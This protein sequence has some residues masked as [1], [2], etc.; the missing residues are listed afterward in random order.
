[1]GTFWQQLDYNQHEE[2]DSVLCTV[3]VVAITKITIIYIEILVFLWQIKWYY[4]VRSLNE[5]KKIQKEVYLCVFM[6]KLTNKL[7]NRRVVS[8]NRQSV[9]QGI[10]IG[11][12]ASDLKWYC[13]ETLECF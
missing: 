6:V 4:T 13:I 10:G 7:A 9:R 11:K 3:Y 8:D 5:A 12:E 2:I 1:M